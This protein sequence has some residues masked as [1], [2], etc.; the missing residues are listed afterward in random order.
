MQ[1]TIQLRLRD[2]H[3]S[4]LN[5]QA[6]AINFV[7]NYCNETSRKAWTRDRRWLSNYD[8]QKMTAGSSKELDLHAHSIV[9]VCAQ[10]TES[11]NKTKR[12]GLRWRGKKSL[13]WVPFNTGH[14]KFRNGAFVFNGKPFE[15]MHN[16]KEISDG[17]KIGAGSFSQDSRGRWYL[18]CPIE[19]ECAVSAPVAHVGVDLG[20]KH[21][22][23]LSDGR[24]IDAPKFYRNAEASII[25]TE[26][27]KKPKKL[28][29]IHAKIRNRRKDFLHK[30]SA[31]LVNEFGFIV[32]G[33]V[34][35][36][37]LAKT[38]RAKSIYDAGWSDFRQMLSY[39]AIMHGGKSVE[40]SEA[41]TSQ[42][43]SGC[44]SIGGPKGIAG[45]AIRQWECVACGTIL[46]R[47][48]NAARNIARAGLCA[49]VEG[50]I[51]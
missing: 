39:K 2:K 7:W 11:R 50:A 29:A 8:L 3:S 27:A 22:A 34:S 40:I 12:A 6:R 30:E 41:Y 5:R 38:T 19:V 45:L 13:G 24:K 49:L 37:N 33:N 15:T 4:E 17:I 36:K 14:V 42:T 48:V 28:K 25:K 23:T 51:L 35:P 47:D 10:F 31:K 46:D 1:I 20:L 18:N 44:G 26:R 32:V 21:F 9:R 43:C 16:R